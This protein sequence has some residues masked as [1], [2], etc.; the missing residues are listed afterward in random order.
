MSKVA[1]ILAEKFNC[2]SSLSTL[3]IFEL[4]LQQKVGLLRPK[5]I[6]KRFLNNS[7]LSFEKVQKTGFMAPRIVKHGGALALVRKS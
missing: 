6:P 5:A 7:K 1:N 4:K 3:R 2:H